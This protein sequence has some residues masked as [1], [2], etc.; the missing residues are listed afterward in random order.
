[1]SNDISEVVISRIKEHGDFYH[2]LFC[3][4]LDEYSD[5]KKAIEVADLSINK[6]K[7]ISRFVFK[8]GETDVSSKDKSLSS[9]EVGVILTKQ[10]HNVKSGYTPEHMEE[11]W[12]S[13]DKFNLV[14]K[15]P[16]WCLRPY[17]YHPPSDKSHTHGPLIVDANKNNA[18]LKYGSFGSD[19]EYL[20]VDGKHRW[21]TS[22]REHK[23][24]YDCFV[25][26]SIRE[27]LERHIKEF[28]P[29]RSKFI[30]DVNSYYKNQTFDN[31]ERVIN[32]GMDCD[33]TFK[34]LN[35]LFSKYKKGIK[36][37][38]VYGRYEDNGWRK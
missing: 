11:K 15:V 36:F 1:M 38:F 18:N 13:S 35:M 12:L 31:K 20:I 25:G 27:D 7:N 22:I 24:F 6:N 2:A 21:W 9:H 29:K 30:I 37:N 8:E 32:S 34:Q 14:K 10:Y 3:V 4:A 16:V 23:P 26:D 5:P 28:G 33:L 17:K 19:S